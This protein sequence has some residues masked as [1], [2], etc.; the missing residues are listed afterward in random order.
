MCLAGNRIVLFWAFRSTLLL[1]GRNLI[2]NQFYTIESFGVSSPA[3]CCVIFWRKRV[4]V[5]RA[6]SLRRVIIASRGVLFPTTFE[7]IRNPAMPPFDN[8]DSQEVTTVT[9]DT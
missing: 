7:N 4:R 5:T 3:I 8:G 1:S 2:R 9:T 6:A